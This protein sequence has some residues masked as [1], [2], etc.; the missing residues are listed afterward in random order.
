MGDEYWVLYGGIW[1]HSMVVVQE[2]GTL[3]L[4]DQNIGEIEKTNQRL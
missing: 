2:R 1:W 4:K 3:V